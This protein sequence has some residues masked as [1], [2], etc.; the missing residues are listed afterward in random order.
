MSNSP[1]VNHTNLS[2]NYS[3]RTVDGKTHPISV[4]TIHHMA[5]NLSVEACGNVF[6]AESRQ[7][8]SNYGIGSDGRIG[9]YV[10]EQY[11]A[12][13]S[14]NRNNDAKAV[15]IEVANCAAGP[16]WPVSEAAFNSLIK[17][18]ADICRRNGIRELNYTGDT[19][20]NLTMHCWFASTLCPGPYLKSRFPEIAA[21]VNAQLA[22]AE[23]PLPAQEKEQDYI[24]YNVKPG[25]TLWAISRA[26]GVSCSKLAEYNGLAN[27]ALIHPGQKIKIMKEGAH[28]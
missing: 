28:G 24:L 18:C 5:G 22:A 10:P 15:T 2:P 12:W 4:I 16:D 11:R 7:A 14:S 6:A 26:H 19:S 1:L 3:S 8:S 20:G 21:L 23:D 25:D 17:L 13:T 9:L 27:P